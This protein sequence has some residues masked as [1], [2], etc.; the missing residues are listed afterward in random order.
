[1]QRLPVR[2]NT[3]RRHSGSL[4]AIIAGVRAPICMMPVPRWM[5]L[6]PREA[7]PRLEPL[8]GRHILEETGCR[9]ERVPPHIECMPSDEPGGP[10]CART[11]VGSRGW[12]APALA[13][14]AGAT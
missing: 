9:N 7:E 11:G 10:A 6:G 5:R 3:Q 8:V 14:R 4:M 1:M 13:H 12:P 2:D